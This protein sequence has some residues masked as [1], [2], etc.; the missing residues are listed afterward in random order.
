MNGSLLYNYALVNRF[1]RQRVSIIN[2]S[3]R[4]TVELLGLNLYLLLISANC[5]VLTNIIDKVLST[6]STVF[7]FYHL[8]ILLYSML[9]RKCFKLLNLLQE[10]HQRLL[11]IKITLPKRPSPQPAWPNYCISIL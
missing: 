3:G 4:R 1:F 5:L 7:I 2:S 9:T 6:I 11:T 8:Q 10:P